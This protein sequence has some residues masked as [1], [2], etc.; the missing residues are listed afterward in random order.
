V[1]YGERSGWEATGI[2]YCVVE[3]LREVT[4]ASDKVR[5]SATLIIQ[6]R[7]SSYE[8][9]NVDLLYIQ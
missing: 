7:T 4:R 1:Y 9:T 8:P 3:V 6:M 5:M 2:G